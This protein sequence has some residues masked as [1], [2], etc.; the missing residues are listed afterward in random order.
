VVPSTWLSIVFFLLLIAPG[1]LFDLLAERRR[2][3]AEESAFR[4]ASRVALGSTVFSGIALTALAV[5][6]AVRPE[7]MP[8]PRRLLSD[9][10]QYLADEYRLVLRALVIQVLLALL[11]AWLTHLTLSKVTGA[12]IRQR[13]AWST[14]FRHDLPAGKQAHARVRLA[15]GTTYVGEVAHFNADLKRADRELVL[16]PPLYSATKGN[17]LGDVPAEWTRVVISADQIAVLSVQYRPKQT[18]TNPKTKRWWQ[19][20][21]SPRAMAG[22]VAE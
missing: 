15:D 10:Q 19:K 17:E 16:A 13:S 9:Q 6:R 3:G 5:V 20:E 18:K 1:L 21:P 8:D 11:L 2:A 7:W 12:P 14:V 4:E 22:D